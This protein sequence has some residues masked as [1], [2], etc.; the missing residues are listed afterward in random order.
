LSTGPVYGRRNRNYISLFPNM[1]GKFFFSL[2]R[3][4]SPSSF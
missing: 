1:E 4:V 2:K 3:D